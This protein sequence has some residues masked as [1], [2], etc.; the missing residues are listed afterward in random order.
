MHFFKVSAHVNINF[1]R[2]LKSTPKNLGKKY[3]L[4]S[5]YSF[6]VGIIITK[7]KLCFLEIPL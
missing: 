2:N 3:I 7:K 4:L 5:S 6:G 1:I